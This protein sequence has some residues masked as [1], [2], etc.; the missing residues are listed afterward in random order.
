MTNNLKI[1][2]HTYKFSYD[3]LG[4]FP[5]TIQHITPYSNLTASQNITS[6][7]LDLI[8]M[9]K[10]NTKKCS[11]IPKTQSTVS[12]ECVSLLYH[13]KSKNPKSNHPK[14]GSIH[15]VFKRSLVW[16]GCLSLFSVPI[17][18]PLWLFPALPQVLSV[19]REK[20]SLG[21]VCSEAWPGSNKRGS[22]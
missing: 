5:I 1:P 2:S 18:R 8:G 16:Q 11:P 12:A 7:L 22:Q 19:H 15:T 20:R 21:G 3:I 10:N 6:L 4:F 13:L 14:S 17:L 9:E